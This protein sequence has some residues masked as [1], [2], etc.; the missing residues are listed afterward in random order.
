MRHS[1]TEKIQSKGQ[2][3][4]DQR[5]IIQGRKASNDIVVPSSVSPSK[6][7]KKPSG[8]SNWSLSAVFVVLGISQVVST[9]V[10]S[11]RV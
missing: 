2:S 3:S 10:E 8:L 5:N 4:D 11:S 1:I 6:P 9:T 7:G